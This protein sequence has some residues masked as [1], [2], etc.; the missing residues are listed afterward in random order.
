MKSDDWQPMETAPLNPYGKPWGPPVLIWDSATGTPISAYFEPWH[1]YKDRDCGPAWV[2]NDG[3]GD[4]AIAPEDA[5]AWMPIAA[6]WAVLNARPTT[7][8]TDDRT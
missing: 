7:G 5:L 8:D 2:V 6:P 3:V 4:S 1:G